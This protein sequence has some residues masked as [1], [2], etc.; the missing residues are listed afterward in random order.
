MAESVFQRSEQIIK[1]KTKRRKNMKILVLM[2]SLVIALFGVGAY[3]MLSDNDYDLPPI[4]SDT[5]DVSVDDSSKPDTDNSDNI[6]TSEPDNST[7]VS[8]PSTDVLTIYTTAGST[9]EFA[10]DMYR[11]EGYHD[12]IG[13]VLAL[14]MHH[15]PE[16]DAEFNVLIYTFKDMKIEDVISKVNETISEEIPIDQ[17]KAVEVENDIIENIKKYY[18][19]LNTEQINVLAENQVKCMYIG[20]G[21]GEYKDMNWDTVEGIKTYCEIRG[22]M[23]TFN[24]R[25]VDSNP[26]I[27]P[28]D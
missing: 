17:L 1:A 22:D 10:A 25:G 3:S 19:I 24:G 11:P 16:D 27:Y 7:D 15:T 20:S 4:I 21:I 13:S 12:N 2:I 6:A 5:S 9:G 8:T 14:M 26:D 23:Y 18:L 28:E